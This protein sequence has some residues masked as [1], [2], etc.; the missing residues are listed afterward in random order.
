MM[1][2]V[3]V[4]L[5][6]STLLFG[7]ANAATI[8]F[9]SFTAG[10][11]LT[12]Q[13]AG[14]T[15]SMSGGPTTATAPIV[16]YGYFDAVLSLNN[17]GNF[18][19]G[20]DGYPTGATVTIDFASAVSGVSFTF[21]NYGNNTGNDSI[22]QAFD[23]ANALISSG[24]LANVNGFSLVNGAGSGIKSL[25][26]SNG[27]GGGYNWIYGVGELSYNGGVPEPAA[28]AMMLAGFGLVGAAMRRRQTTQVTYA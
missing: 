26:I 17:S 22:Y 24:S 13:V 3:S 28:W 10:T 16:G 18:G 23:A 14:L 7:T 6:A 27:S 4:A 12:N 5:L 8:N 2:K 11:V 19:S 15:F 21:N 25:V 1:K 20:T 9:G